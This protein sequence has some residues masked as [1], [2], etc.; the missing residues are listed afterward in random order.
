V[1][2]YGQQEFG[3][4]HFVKLEDCRQWW[5]LP[6]VAGDHLQIDWEVQ[7]PYIVLRLY[8]LGTSD[9]N[10]PQKSTLAGGGVNSNTKAEFTYI[11][12][13]TGDLPM[14]FTDPGCHGN[15]E[16]GP[17]NFTAYV[18]HSLVVG[19]PNITILH[20]KGVVA[21]AVHDP[22]GGEINN[23]AITCTFQIKGRSRWTTVGTA[24]VANSGATI[25]FTVPARLRHQR[26]TLRS[27]VTGTGY[28]TASSIDRKARTL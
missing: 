13:Q 26:V 6:S 12:E 7:D 25:H 5:L 27:V 14:L 4:L 18:T 23:P 19:P 2:S 9:F 20:A 8:P 3:Y 24:P 10:F 22:A 15:A 28:F 21:V 17:Y 11:S 1:V 16:P